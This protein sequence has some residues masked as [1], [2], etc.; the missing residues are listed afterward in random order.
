MFYYFIL[1][2]CLIEIFQW[3]KYRFGFSNQNIVPKA[4]FNK[5]NHFNFFFK[6]TEVIREDDFEVSLT[7]A[8]ESSDVYILKQSDFAD[9]KCESQAGRQWVLFKLNL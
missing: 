2:K 3:K 8:V 7:D 5:N 4:N 9:V 1:K 6:F